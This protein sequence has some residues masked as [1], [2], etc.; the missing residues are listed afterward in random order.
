MSI[1]PEVLRLVVRR[2]GRPRS[3]NPVKGP[4]LGGRI[5]DRKAYNRYMRDYMRTYKKPGEREGRDA[6][7]ATYDPLRD[8]PIVH[9]DA[10]AQIMG[11]PPIGRRAI[12][13]RRGP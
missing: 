7:A 5:C 4:V 2:T 13:K 1:D 8:G 12:D 11:D 10:C 3:A 6:S 9:T